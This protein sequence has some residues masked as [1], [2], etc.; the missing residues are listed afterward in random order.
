MPKKYTGIYLD[1]AASTPVDPQV[2]LVVAETMQQVYGNP[3]SIHGFGLRAKSILDEGRNLIAAIL[4]ARPDEIFFTSGGSESNNLA[5]Q[6]VAAECR[7]PGNIIISAIEHPSTLQTCRYLKTHGWE[8]TQLPVNGDGQIDPAELD[9][10]IQPETA[11]ISIMHVNNEIGSI[12]DIETCAQIA[13]RKNVL[14]HTDAVQSFGKMPVDLSKT[15]ISLMSFTGHKIYGPKG[16]GVLFK[17]R[18]VK[19]A[20]MIHGGSQESGLRAGTENIPAIAGLCKAVEIIQQRQN[21]DRALAQKLGQQL[22]ELMHLKVPRAQQNGSPA[23]LPDIQNYAIPGIDNLSFL[24]G[25]DLAGIAISNGSACSSGDISPSHVLQALHL[26]EKLQNASV[27][28]SFGRFTSSEEIET[29]VQAF[30]HFL[31]KK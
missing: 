15:P 6:G 1:Y 18:A 31:Q 29:A 3:S 16:A 2:A 25:M 13:A 19:I 27:R 10:T 9:R 24:M 8:I 22:R 11:L 7:K 20:K 17:R 26:P 12:N 30:A 23:G 21:E 28:I 14:F 5:I 4:H